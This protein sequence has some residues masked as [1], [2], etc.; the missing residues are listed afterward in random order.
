MQAI[1]DCNL[2]PAWAD[3]L[4]Q[5]GFDAHAWWERGDIRASDAEIMATARAEQAV[6]L[7]HDLDMGMISAHAHASGPSVLQFRGDDVMPDH[8][9]SMALAIMSR[10]A[11]ALAQGAIVAISADRVRVS[12]LPI[13]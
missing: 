6:I 8:L 11:H 1:I 7:T 2:P 3:L 10:Y 5:H 13:T 12:I 4:R 9:G